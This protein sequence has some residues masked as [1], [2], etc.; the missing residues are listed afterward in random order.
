[1][2]EAQAVVS[3]HLI[4]GL[5]FFMPRAWRYKLERRLR[6]KEEYRK[7]CAADWVLMS[8]A[9]S[10]RTWFR[11]M[12]S[13]F[14]QIRHNLPRGNLLEFDNL[15]RK[16]PAIPRVLFSHNNYMRDYLKDWDTLNYYRGKKV[17]ML[18]RDP[19][20]VAVSQYFQWKYRM[21]PH[22]IRL[23]RFP[24]PGDGLSIFDFATNPRS[25]IPQIINF[26]NDWASA[27][28]YLGDILIIHYEDMRKDPAA[29][30]RQVLEFVGTPGSDVEIAQAVEYASMENMK[31]REEKSDSRGSSM[32]VKSGDSSNPESFKTRRGKVGGY[33]DY[34]DDEQVAV[35]DKL[36]EEGLDPVFGYTAAAKVDAVSVVNGSA[37]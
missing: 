11:V 14:Y 4:V 22:K 12:L 29:I 3:R 8:W 18:V 5:L 37:T 21:R 33:R 10:G 17:V 35:V 15:Y 16:N 28:P 20:D 36:V 19:R 1:M 30:M 23:N 24:E 2:R 6:G 27:L 31:E 32:R 26:Y 13:R 9:K 7:L 34:F 25:G